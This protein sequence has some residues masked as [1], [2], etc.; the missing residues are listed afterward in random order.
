MG[1]LEDRQAIVSGIN[2]AS[3]YLTGYVAARWDG[4]RTFV[5]QSVEAI[6]GLLA[7]DLSQGESG[8]SGAFTEAFLIGMG[9]LVQLLCEQLAGAQ[10]TRQVDTLRDA[11]RRLG[12]RINAAAEARP[13]V[14]VPGWNSAE[15]PGCGQPVFESEPHTIRGTRIDGRIV[16][17]ALHPGCSDG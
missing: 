6:Q 16:S 8:S 3:S 4:D 1:A 7:D 11:V 14:P 10:G 5:T 12:G 17:H 2:A 15:C 9:D 13:P